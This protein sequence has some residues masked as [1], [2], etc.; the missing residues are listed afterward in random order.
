MDPLPLS[1]KNLRALLDAGDVEALS[2]VTAAGLVILSDDGS[3]LDGLASACASLPCVLVAAPAAPRLAP[4]IDV[5]ATDDEVLAIAAQVEQTPLAATAMVLLLRGGAVRTID[6]G[7]VAESVTYSML[8]GGPE[9]ARWRAGRSRRERAEP[10]EVVHTARAGD[11]LTITLTRPHVH[12]A[13]NSAIRDGL[14][15]ALTIAVVDESITEIVLRGAGPS[16]CSGGD[17][18]E[19][20]RFPDPASSHLIRLTRSP[21]R[22]VAH[23]ADR[24][25][26]HAHGSC[27][28]AGMELPSFAGRVIAHPDARFA[29]PELSLGLVP[30]AGGTVSLPR[31]IGRHRTAWLALTGVVLDAATALEWGLIDGLDASISGAP[32]TS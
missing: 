6:E 12:N 2:I 3:D 19:F 13:F 9:F 20:G 15:E 10:D 28:G 30:G 4:I 29:L 32:P 11:R 26:V 31:R 1:V 18:D 25:V 22:L 27:V 7:L 8:Q 24:V 23:L 14:V 5:F 21:A 16:F 17:L